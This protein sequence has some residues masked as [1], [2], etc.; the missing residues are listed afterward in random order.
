[1]LQSPIPQPS[2]LAVTTLKCS[3]CYTQIQPGMT[4][5]PNC[6]CQEFLVK[7]GAVTE[8]VTV[9]N[10]HAKSSNS[11]SRNSPSARSGQLASRRIRFAGL[12]IDLTI[13][14][15]TCAIGWLV[16]FIILAPQGQTPAKR[17]LKIK[18][19]T[20]T[21]SNPKTIVTLSRYFIPNLLNWVTAPFA[22]LGLVSLPYAFALILGILEFFAWLVPTVDGLF[23]LGPRKKRLVDLMFK[24]KV[25]YQ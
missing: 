13:A 6:G 24:T 16:W 5:C 19:V 20:D 25:V 2:A 8:F 23:V 17:I 22:I 7:D 4:S 9:H 14:G 18:L 15:C 3:D 1:V 11:G 21:G 10:S 12:L